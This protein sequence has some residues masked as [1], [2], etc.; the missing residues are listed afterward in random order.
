MAITSAEGDLE[1]AEQGLRTDGPLKQDDVSEWTAQL[2]ETFAFDRDAAC[3]GK[4]DEGEVGPG[5]LFLEKFEERGEG[6][7][8]RLR[9]GELRGECFF[10]DNSCGGASAELATEVLEG[11][12]D[13]KREIEAVQQIADQLSIAANG[14]EDDGASFEFGSAT[15]RKQDRSPD[16]T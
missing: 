12:G 2:P 4:E 9:A 11:V 5:G 14:S 7:A 6:V 13:V 1:G 15:S 10:R 8:D 16:W 3:D